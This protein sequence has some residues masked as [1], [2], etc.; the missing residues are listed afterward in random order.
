MM[1]TSSTITMVTD[2]HVDSGIGYYS[3]ELTKAMHAH[4]D[5]VLVKPYRSNHPDSYLHEQYSWLRKA[6][7]KSLRQL[8]PYILPLF[9]RQAM[10]GTRGALYHAHWLLSGLA[11]TYAHRGPRVVTMHDVSLL[12]VSDSNDRYLAYYRWGLNR[13]KRLGIPLI[14]VSEQ[15]RQDTIQYAGY[16]EELVFAVHNGINF[17]HFYPTQASKDTS[18]FTLVYSG[19]LGK[20]KNVDLLLRAYQQLQ[21]HYDFIKLKIA[22]SHPE[23]TPYP[24]LATAL[25]LRDVTFMGFVPDDQMNAFYNSGDLL[26]YTS[27]YEGFGLAPLEGMACGLPVVSTRGGALAEVSGGGAHLVDDHED[28]LVGAIRRVIDDAVYRQELTQ[29]GQ[30]WVQ[31]YTW[32]RAAQRTW[33][34]Y[35]TIL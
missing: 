26:V 3:V 13:F 6:P 35:Q 2:H 30:Q 14:V 29:R 4:H 25:G 18:K 17:D 7:Y 31:Q 33:D 32:S 34:V 11:A 8:R 10:M 12:H 27:G 20:R 23:R 16:P 5:A 24:A 28:D 1:A 9:L 19:G 15:A 21:R 22:G